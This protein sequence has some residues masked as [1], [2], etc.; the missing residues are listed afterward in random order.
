MIKVGRPAKISNRSRLACL[1]QDSMEDVGRTSR[2][3]VCLVGRLRYTSWFGEPDK[4]DGKRHKGDIVSIL[5]HAIVSD[6]TP[7]LAAREPV[8]WTRSYL[9]WA[10]L[11]DSGC[12]LL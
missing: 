4:R 8:P 2:K 9:R 11:T 3:P 10:A 1:D 6:R 7:R 5:D 12:G